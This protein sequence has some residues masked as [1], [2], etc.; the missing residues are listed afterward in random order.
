MRNHLICLY[1]KGEPHHFHDRDK[2]FTNVK[3]DTATPLN[4]AYPVSLKFPFG[5]LKIPTKR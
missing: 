4:R 3:K 2:S 1:L 5:R